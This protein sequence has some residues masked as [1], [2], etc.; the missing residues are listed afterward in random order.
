MTPG[1]FHMETSNHD[2]SW[3]ELYRWLKEQPDD[4]KNGLTDKSTAPTSPD[5]STP[6]PGDETDGET[7][8]S[9]AMEFNSQSENKKQDFN[10]YDGVT[11]TNGDGEGLPTGMHLFRNHDLMNLLDSKKKSFISFAARD[12]SCTSERVF[13]DIKGFIDR[14][15]GVDITS[16]RKEI[17]SIVDYSSQSD[18]WIYTYGRFNRRFFSNGIYTP[19]RIY[20]NLQHITVVVDV[21][22]SMVM[23][24][25]D[26]EAAFG[27]IEVLLR[28]YIVH[29]LCIDEDL[30]I[31]E[32]KEDGFVPGKSKKPYIYR[33]GDWKYIRTGSSGTTFFTPLFNNFMKKHREMLLV[34]TDGYIYDMDQ[35]H[36]YHPTLWVISS[37][38]K[39][40]F[41]PPFGKAVQIVTED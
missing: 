36:R 39:D 12:E 17:K 9:D 19:G 16:W 38:R 7:V 1:K 30:F 14:T 40:P 22:A 10:M 20:K 13:Q 3:E 6:G 24:P 18:E 41:D 21:S 4:V 11:F 15:R 29:L 27:L 23:N 32:I 37:N 2:P 26:I 33:K 34:I 35:L 8:P 31:P 28:K 25:S 5:S